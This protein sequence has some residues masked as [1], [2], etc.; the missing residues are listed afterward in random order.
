MGK[1]GPAAWLALAITLI[2]SPAVVLAQSARDQQ[3]PFWL[4]FDVGAAVVQSLA[5]A[6]SAGRD[7]LAA[8]IELGY[9]FAPEW[10]LGLEYGGV[11]PFSGCAQ[12]GCGQSQQDFAPNFSRFF[13]F[14][15]YRARDSGVR[16]RAGFGVSRFCYRRHWSEDAW[17]WVD[18]INF[19]I[20][21]LLDDDDYGG[22]TGAWR[23]D[24][25]RK[26]LG[27]SLSVGYDWPVANN[28]GSLGVRLT[29]E[30]ADYDRTPGADLPAFR[31]RALLLTVHL[32]LH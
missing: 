16:L 8:S 31:H 17:S 15:E 12:S 4:G 26:A 18:T 23:C 13:A 1:R 2:A 30:A 3:Q 9:R 24:A 22:G 11:V 14:G 28:S 19:T 32:N 25:A 27:G 7:G 20:S 6:P 29:A 10:G 21:A 5:P